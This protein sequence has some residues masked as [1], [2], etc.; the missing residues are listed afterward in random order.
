MIAVSVCNKRFV[1]AL[2]RIGVTDEVAAD[3]L[4]LLRLNLWVG[5][6]PGSR[7]YAS[8]ALDFLLSS[9]VTSWGPELRRL[10]L[11]PYIELPTGA[12]AACLQA[13]A[14]DPLPCGTISTRR[15]G[16]L[17]RITSRKRRWT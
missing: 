2:I 6:M 11:L 4:P 10:G 12:A 8:T 14:P 13:S 7:K 17:G 16:Q 5:P 9:E 1:H 3:R 15:L